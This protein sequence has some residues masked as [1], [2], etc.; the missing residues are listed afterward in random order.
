MRSSSE[1]TLSFNGDARVVAGLLTQAGEAIEQRALA[2]IR[3]AYDRDTGH[4]MVAY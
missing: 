3:V 4:R 2:R 1:C